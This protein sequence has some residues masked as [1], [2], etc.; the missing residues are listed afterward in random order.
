VLGEHKDVQALQH[1]GARVQEVDCEDPGGL[2]V[3]EL[4]PRRA[5]AARRRIDTRGM[6]DLPDGGRRDRNAEFRQ[7][8][9]DPPVPP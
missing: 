6:Q 3:K 4:P 1:H 2:G 8:A 5:Q 7:L 9:A